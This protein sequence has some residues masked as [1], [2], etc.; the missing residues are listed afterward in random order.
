[1]VDQRFKES[2]VLI[3]ICVF[4]SLYIFGCD[5]TAKAWEE[6][7][8]I[9]CTSATCDHL[10]QKDGAQGG[11]CRGGDTCACMGYQQ[12]ELSC[13]P[14]DCDRKCHN[15]D[16]GGY[17]GGICRAG[18]C[19]CLGAP[20]TIQDAGGDDGSVKPTN[21]VPAQCDQ[22]CLANQDLG[23]VC[24]ND[25]CTCIANTTPTTALSCGQAFLCI[26]A[27]VTAGQYAQM[28][29]CVAKADAQA[30]QNIQALVTCLVQSGC[31]TPS[32]MFTCLVQNCGTELST[33]LADYT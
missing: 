8:L 27:A 23:G 10:C 30:K 33:C 9:N 16:A 25:K 31:T 15:Q 5:A 3:V 7:P 1:M 6:I 22:T 21:C 14:Y 12:P 13:N 32:T 20:V 26:Y 2:F 11:V 29:Q 28:A 19:V 18:E 4:S 24:R 17:E